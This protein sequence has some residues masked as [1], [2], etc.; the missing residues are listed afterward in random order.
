VQN[1]LPVLK[2]HNPHIQ[3]TLAR[4]TEQPQ[5]VAQLGLNDVSLPRLC[6]LI[7]DDDEDVHC[8]VWCRQLVS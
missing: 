5:L 2:Y 7:Y 6:L 8:M 4:T 1:F 3:W